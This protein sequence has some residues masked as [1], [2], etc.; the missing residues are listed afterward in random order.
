MCETQEHQSSKIAYQQLTV[1]TIGGGGVEDL[2]SHIDD[3][4]PCWALLRCEVPEAGLVDEKIVAIACHDINAD[5]SLSAQ[6]LQCLG[7]ADATLRVAHGRELKEKLGKSLKGAL[8][9]ATYPGNF[10]LSV[11]QALS[12]VGSEMNTLNWLLLE[13]SKLDVHHAGSGGL[14]E[15]KEWLSVDKVMFGVLR[16]SFPRTFSAPPIVKYLFIHWIGPKVSVVRRGQWNTKLEQASEKLRT[17]CDFAFRK[18]AYDLEDLVLGN[19]IEELGRVTCITSSD[20]RQLSVEWYREGLSAASSAIA[21]QALVCPSDETVVIPSHQLH[22]CSSIPFL[23]ESAQ[24]AID[25]V[26]AGRQWKWVLLTMA[27]YK[28]PSSGGA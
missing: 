13:P 17:S 10:E 2:C 22:Q 8:D 7:R 1:H 25:M 23:R 12:D 15:L 21:S 4:V 5:K 6:V 11:E 9:E 27:E 26:R 24:Y 3:A 18:T 20:T 19:L 14:D 16:F 28:I